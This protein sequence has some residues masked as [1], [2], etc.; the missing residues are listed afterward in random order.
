MLSRFR[1]TCRIAILAALCCS[2]S[3]TFTYALNLE[4]DGGAGDN[5]WDGI[6]LVPDLDTNWSENVFADSDDAIVLTG[7]SAA[8]PVAID[9]NGD[10]EIIR[11][12][13]STVAGDYAFGTGIGSDTLTVFGTGNVL[14]NESTDGDLIVNANVALNA[15]GSL[16]RFNSGSTTDD[17]QGI[18][19]N[20]NVAPSAA[21]TGDITLAITSTN[22]SPGPWVT[23][24]GAISDG[25]MAAINLI[26]GV[27]T[28][29]S[30]T[31]TA[32]HSGEVALLGA[33]TFTGSVQVTGGTLVFNSIQDAGSTTPNALGTPNVAN[34]AI[35]IGD[36]SI[37][38]STL[39]YVGSST[40]SNSSDRDIFVAGSSSQVTIE[41]A[42]SVPL[43][44]SGDVTTPSSTTTRTLRLGGENTGDNIFAGRIFEGT[45]SGVL[46]VR[47]VDAGKWVLSGA[48]P[49]LDGSV[50]AV[51]GDL[52]LTGS[53]GS[54]TSV[55]G[56]FQTNNA[57]T[58]TLDGGYL[59][60]TN[61]SKSPSGVINF[62]SGTVRVTAASN[63]SSFT[64]ALDIG[65]DGAGTLQLQGGS[66]NFD[67]VTL[68]G[69]DDTI[70]I[71][72][73]GTWAFDKLDNSN[74]GTLTFTGGTINLT[75]ASAGQGLITGAGTIGGTLTGAG[76]V[77]KIGAGKLTLNLNTHTNF[78]KT[79]INQGVLEVTENA[80][81]SDGT[82]VNV[83][84]GATL[85]FLTT[86]T[87]AIFGLEGA[88]TV[89]LGDANLVVGNSTGTGTAGGVGVF[90]G[91][92]TDGP[93]PASSILEKRGSG[94]FT[95]AGNST[96]SGLTEVENGTMV[97]TGNI[98][99]TSSVNVPNGPL[100]GAG[101]LIIDGGTIV[102]AGR[103]AADQSGARLDMNSG[104]LTASQIDVVAGTAY[105]STFT[106]TSGSIRLT[107]PN[108]VDIGVGPSSDQP[109][110]NNL[111]LTT[112]KSLSVDLN[113]TEIGAS[114][115][116]SL[117]G[118]SLTTRAIV[119]SSSGVFEFNSG[120]LRLV[121]NHTLDTA[122]LEKLDLDTGL[123]AGQTLEVSNVARIGTALTLAG[124]TLS[125]GTLENPGNLILSS[126]TLQTVG[127]LTVDVGERLEAFSGMTIETSAGIVGLDNAGEVSLIG[128]QANFGAASINQATG[129]INAINANL[130]FA[131]GLTNNGDVNLINSTINGDLVNGPGGSASLLGSNTFNDDLVL[132]ASSNLFIDITS[133]TQ[134]D[135]I[136]VDEE[137]TLAGQ[138]NVSLAG[139]LAPTLGQ[140]FTVLSAGNIIDNGLTLGG[141]AASL[142]SM[143]IDSTSVVLEAVGIAGD[144]N[145]DLVVDMRDYTLWRDNLGAAAGTLPN[146]IDGGVIGEAQYATWQSNFGNS[147]SGSLQATPVP[148]PATVA[149]AALLGWAFCATLRTPPSR[150]S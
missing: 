100:S 49:S 55:A 126:G 136:S 81:L 94:T 135:V 84:S 73:S 63:T 117:N 120:R 32:D 150:N 48:S 128:S 69:A 27:E 122:E 143:S 93:A 70:E 87:D 6:E 123:R 24:N 66:K 107:G 45:G 18:I 74:G 47:K 141:S 103:V 33:N 98:T 121:G 64:G 90:T 4:W 75:D 31:I 9:L 109:F 138:L 34:S 39:R 51:E 56:P 82:T 130:T 137:A 28:A 76:D 104:S 101:R 144:Y 10:R 37:T 46:N 14:L 13:K 12:T 7:A 89:E 16:L 86:S 129:E 3:F 147:F 23:V 30:Q 50:T 112:G 134:F 142:F 38:S 114:G 131:G 5:L 29:Q 2:F 59:A 96:H 15:G 110:Q 148:E 116:L 71:G 108:G 139:G 113:N 53:I 105:N 21:A 102:S 106:W 146:D 91:T 72:G 35:S 88:G 22:L 149:M 111:D 41:A 145:G 43:T 65:T 79:N 17:S 20:G 97:V 26:A 125:V 40:S 60:T 44:L 124:G 11:I 95:F 83:A 58:F 77:T 133:D 36:A 52:V 67:D 19:V 140:Q 132:T 68:D 62:Q 80:R 8:G 1:S 99:N 61:F 57:G 115:T 127:D 25:P 78:G 42:G 92:I 54:T 118:G 119:K 85:R